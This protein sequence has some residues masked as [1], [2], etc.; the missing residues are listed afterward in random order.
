MTIVIARI[1]RFLV[2]EEQIKGG[3]LLQKTKTP[4]RIWLFGRVIEAERKRLPWIVREKCSLVVKTGD[5]FIFTWSKWLILVFISKWVRSKFE[6]CN[7]PR[8]NHWVTPAEKISSRILLLNR[9]LLVITAVGF[10][11][12]SQ[13]MR[14]RWWHQL[15]SISRMRSNHSSGP[16][17]VK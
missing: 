4:V 1:G 15:S 7:H 6:W 13:S 9:K 14:N 5:F 10:V 12:R 11:D 2:R 8:G 16:T 3:V 17:G